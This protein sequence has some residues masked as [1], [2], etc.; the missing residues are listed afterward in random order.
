MA[1]TLDGEDQWTCTPGSV[2]EVP[3]N[4]MLFD[5]REDPFQ[6]SNILK[7]DGKKATE[8]YKTLRNFLAEQLAC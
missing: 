1:A 3:D 7:K 5:R 2:A 8:L 6:L 4:D